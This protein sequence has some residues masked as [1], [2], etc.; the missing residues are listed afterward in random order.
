MRRG[1]RRVWP[2]SLDPGESSATGRRTPEAAAAKAATP[3]AGR[4]GLATGRRDPHRRSRHRS[5]TAGRAER[6][7]AVPDR[8][9][10]RGRGLGLRQ[11]GRRRRG[12]LELLCLQ[13]RRLPRCLGARLARERPEYLAEH[14]SRQRDRGARD[15]RD[16]AGGKGK[17]PAGK[18]ATRS[19][20]RRT[21]PARR[22]RR[23]R[24]SAASGPPTFLHPAAFRRRGTPPGPG[25]RS[26]P[27]SPSRTSPTRWAG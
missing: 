15:R 8:Q 25:G 22:R 19:G 13:F 24:A 10:R 17:A 27:R 12:D 11:S 26:R 14:G 4:A 1:R 18:G 5:R 16:L 2:R 3:E 6:A 20:R 7:D 9:G 21:A 23:Q